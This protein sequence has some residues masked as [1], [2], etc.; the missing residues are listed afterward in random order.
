MLLLPVKRNAGTDE[1]HP[2]IKGTVLQAINK[3]H[4]ANNIDLLQALKPIVDV[5]DLL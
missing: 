4:F 1:N 3:L 2:I 5:I